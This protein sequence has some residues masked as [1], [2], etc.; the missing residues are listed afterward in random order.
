MR[1]EQRKKDRVNE[2]GQREKRECETRG[3]ET[4]L[5]EDKEGR[6]GSKEKTKKVERKIE[7]CL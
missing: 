5:I 4:R 3:G 2:T 7:A 1:E 6:K